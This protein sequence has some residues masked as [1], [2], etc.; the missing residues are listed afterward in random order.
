MDNSEYRITRC[1][2]RIR[3]ED[4]EWNVSIIFNAD[5]MAARLNAQWDID[6][7]IFELSDF[8]ADS[9]GRV[10]SRLREYAIAHYPECFTLLFP[11]NRY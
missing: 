3:I 1:G 2:N 5:D 11:P 8:D 6:G 7:M 10:I 9:L 4:L